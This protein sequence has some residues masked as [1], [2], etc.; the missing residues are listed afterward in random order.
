MLTSQGFVPT[1]E[2][3]QSCY[4][5]PTLNLHLAV[6][7]DDFKIA[8]PKGKMAKLWAD[9]KATGLKLDDPTEFHNSVYL[10]CCQYENHIL[11]SE[12]K[13]HTDFFNQTFGDE[14]FKHKTAEQT[15]LT[16]DRA[17]I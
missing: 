17:E 7:V 12:V 4:Y 1:G 16:E 11:E 8:A 15:K 5:H 6:Y 2:A 9:I 13:L 10:G 14:E 3:W